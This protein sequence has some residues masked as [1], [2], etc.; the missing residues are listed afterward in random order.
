MC[1]KPDRT[2]AG[3]E[4][5]AIW[6]QNSKQNSQD[7]QQKISKT[8]KLTSRP[9]SWTSRHS[10]WFTSLEQED[11]G[12][13]SL[14]KQQTSLDDNRTDQ[15]WA[16]QNRT[17]LINIESAVARSSCS[18]RAVGSGCS[19]CNQSLLVDHS[20]L[21]KKGRPRHISPTLVGIKARAS[22]HISPTVVGIK[23]R[24]ARHISPTLVGIKSDQ[25]NT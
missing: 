1:T 10:S 19:C 18:L 9:L 12:Q 20:Q 2:Q 13:N 17:E 15:L 22:P 21:R 11:S 4:I 3:T 14:V 23:A 8:S 6:F 5:N 25:L 16:K 7:G 24:E